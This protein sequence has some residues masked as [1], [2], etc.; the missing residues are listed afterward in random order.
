MQ[1]AEVGER[2]AHRQMR[3]VRQRQFTDVHMAGSAIEARAL[4]VCAHAGAAIF[5]QFFA[6][7]AGLGLGIAAFE[8]GQYALEGMH[9]FAG[10]AARIGIAELHFLIATA[11]Q[12]HLTHA[13]V[14]LV[15]RRVAVKL[16]VRRQRTHH[17]KVIRVAPVPA[18]YGTAGQ[19]QLRMGHNPLRI[20]ELLIAQTIATRASTRRVVEREH[21]RF[22]QRHAV[23]ALRAGVLARESHLGA[24]VGFG[25]GQP[26]NA[27]AQT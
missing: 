27:I 2:I 20:E 1:G 15:P 8:V 6:H 16:V 19:R 3:R 11:V 10:L 14:Q 26:G 17:L 5:A 22:Q 13:D 21:L 9:A 24:L 18:A 4:A 25:K 7:R 12:D 23:T